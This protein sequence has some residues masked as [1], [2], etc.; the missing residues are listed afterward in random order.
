[1]EFM[2]V[3]VDS[4]YNLFWENII[5]Y[6]RSIYGDSDI[7]AN[8]MFVNDTIPTANGNYDFHLAEIFTC[9]R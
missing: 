8:P 5:D 2:V 3:T 7:V 9:N 1:M 6:N 4:D